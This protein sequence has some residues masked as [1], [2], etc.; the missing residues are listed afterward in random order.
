MFEDGAEDPAVAVIIGKLRVLQFRIQLGDVLE[1]IHVTPQPARG[2][3]FRI[4]LR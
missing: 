2:R 3:G 1:K 4:Y